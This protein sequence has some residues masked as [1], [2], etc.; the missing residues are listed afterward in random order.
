MRGARAQVSATPTSAEALLQ[1]LEEAAAAYQRDSTVPGASPVAAGSTAA[2]RGAA[3]LKEK[4]KHKLASSAKQYAEEALQTAIDTCGVAELNE[5]K[6]AI[7]AHAAAAEGSPVLKQARRAPSHTPSERDL[8]H[9]P[10]ERPSYSSLGET[11]LFFP[12]PLGAPL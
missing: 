4:L 9:T 5:L 10:S 3:A 11:R 12:Q 6:G 2:L 8:P 7:S 1:Q